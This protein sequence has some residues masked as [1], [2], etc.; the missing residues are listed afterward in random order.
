M[1]IA[2]DASGNIYVADAWCKV[3]KF[4]SNGNYVTTIGTSKLASG[5]GDMIDPQDVA[6]DSSGNI[7]VVDLGNSRV[8]EFSSSGIYLSQFGSYGTGPGQFTY[9]NDI[10]FD[11][12]GNIYVTNGDPTYNQIQK[13][14]SNGTFLLQF[15]ENGLRRPYG[16]AIH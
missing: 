14:S 6:I 8:Q 3:F 11:S 9:I 5:N 4:N 10:A 2:L 13:F 12:S 15:N 7:W 16:I 1:G